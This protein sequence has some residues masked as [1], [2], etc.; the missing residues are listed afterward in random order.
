MKV[1]LDS[2]ANLRALRSQY[3]K[4]SVKWLNKIVKLNTLY[5]NRVRKLEAK[6]RQ[7]DELLKD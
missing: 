1:K 2:P 7:I 4:E 6:I 5:S 3:M